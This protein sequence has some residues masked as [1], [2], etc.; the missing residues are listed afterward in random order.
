MGLIELILLLALVGFAC[1]LIVTYIPMPEPMK[2]LI[3]VIV[4]V[5]VVLIL[6][7]V[8]G[9]DVAVPRLGGR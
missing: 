1:Y 8:F 4:A 2:M 7:R 5:C 9:L 6:V 3:Y